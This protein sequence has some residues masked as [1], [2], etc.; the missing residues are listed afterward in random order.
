MSSEQND[1]E[2]D[3]TKMLREQNPDNI[4]ITLRQAQGDK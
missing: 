3:A 2:C 4:K 1:E